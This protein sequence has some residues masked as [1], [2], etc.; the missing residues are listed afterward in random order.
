[1][2]R[3]LKQFT[4][5][6]WKHIQSYLAEFNQKEAVDWAG[7]A[8]CL[9]GGLLLWPLVH[10]LPVLGMDW[11]VYFYPRYFEGTYP[12]WAYAVMH[13]FIQI[14][15]RSSFSLANSL[16]MMTLAVAT[17]RQAVGQPRIS[18]Y[19][20]VVLSV[21]MPI[22]FMLLW[23]GNVDGLV[24]FGVVAMPLGVPLALLK[25][26]VAGWV[27]F[28]RRSWLIWAAGFG[29]LSLLIWGWWPGGM[30][31][32]FTTRY[33]HP[34]TM[35]WHN[36]GWPL[37]LIGVAMLLTS[38]AD[39]YRLMAA[40]SFLAPYLMPVHYLVLVPAIGRVSGWKRWLLWGWT[41]VVGLVPG[42]G[43]ITKYLALGFP[44]AVWWLLRDAPLPGKN[45]NLQN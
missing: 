42:F 27:I 33:L 38:N 19:T 13:P 12:P 11:L 21:F 7:I 44:F 18:R 16:T 5:P 23:Q 8:V 39:P 40:G 22:L 43:G 9:G 6:I 2:N 41:W 1:M 24:L 15:W 4:T 34:M 20:A 45:S 35:G 37:A 31:D 36:L 32:A 26:T 3:T 25:P 30:T 10:R 17:A 28:A 29:V 14:D